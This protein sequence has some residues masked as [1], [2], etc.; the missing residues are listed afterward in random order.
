MNHIRQPESFPIVEGLP[1]DAI[2]ELALMMRAAYRA[3]QIVRAG[4]NEKQIVDEKEHGNLVSK[5]DEDCDEA[6]HDEIK[7]SRPDETILSEEKNHDADISHGKAWVVD[8]LDA[9]SAFL[10]GVSEDMPSIMI[11]RTEDGVANSSIVYFPLTDEMFYAVR[12]LGAYK[13]KDRLRCTGSTLAESWI[14]MNQQ[15]NAS[16]E[17]Q[18]FSRMR[19]NLRQPGGARLVSSSPPHSGIGVRIAEGRKRLSAVVHDNNP[20]EPAKAKQAPWD[21]I[22]VALILEEA[23]GVVVNFDGQPYNPFKPE[24]FIMAASKELAEEIIE[25]SKLR[26]V[27]G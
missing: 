25:R 4:Y 18:V 17:S 15:A 16:K 10:F 23:G 27:I 26:G 11:A 1:A 19:N 22:P 5:V 3:G 20:G 9:T 14:E 13:G 8:P 2:D 12:G 24:P 21:V 7:R 6:V